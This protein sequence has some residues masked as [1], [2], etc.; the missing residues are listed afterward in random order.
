[1]IEFITPAL[2]NYRLELFEKLDKEYSIK[3]IFTGHEKVREFGGMNIPNS[4]NYENTN[5]TSARGLD[6]INNNNFISWLRFARSLL[7]D[8]YE[9][10][11]SSPA[12]HYYN[13]VTLIV[14]KLRFKK[15]IFWG[16]SWYW[17]SNRIVL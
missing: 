14:S 11:L 6:T 17:P 1:M 9:L 8:K 15:I 4:W 5:I 12:E 16:E 10:I 13:L 2:R 3:F 7:S